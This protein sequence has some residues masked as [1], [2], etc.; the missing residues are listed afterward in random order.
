MGDLGLELFE[1]ICGSYMNLWPVAPLSSFVV[2]VSINELVM[3]IKVVPSS[4]L[5]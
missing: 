2:I 1:T 5:S 4:S 3:Q